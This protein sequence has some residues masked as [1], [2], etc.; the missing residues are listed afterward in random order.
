MVV[1]AA[2]ARYGQDGQVMA[3]YRNVL[4]RVHT[5]PGVEAAG[6]V[7]VLPF[8][9]NYENCGFFIEEK[10]LANPAESGGS[11]FGA[12]LRR[13][14]GLLARNGHPIAARPAIQRAGQRKR[15]AGCVDQQDGGGTKLAK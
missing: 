7:S 15:A 12:T 11:A 1:P 6:I 9:A 8:S 4:D 10:P 3:F 14:P 2:G 13:Q 5:L